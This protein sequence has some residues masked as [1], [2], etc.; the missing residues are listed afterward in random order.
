MPLTN[1]G[2][3]DSPVNL[4]YQLYGN[5]PHKVLCV[6]GLSTSHKAWIFNI[7]ELQKNSDFQICAFDN[8]GCGQSDYPSGRYTTTLM[9]QDAI[10]LLRN[11]GPEWQAAHVVGV[12]MGGMIAQ[13]MALALLDQGIKLASLTL[14]VTHAGRTVA[15]FSGTWALLQTIFKK[16]PEEKAPLVL[17]AVHSREFLES[18]H[19][20][21]KTKYDWVAEAYLERVKSDPP[22]RLSG[23]I[24]HISAVS[25]HHVSQERLHQLR[26]SGIPICIITG[27]NDSLVWHH[28]SFY[29]KDHLNPA[30]FIVW[31]GVGHGVLLERFEEFNDALVRNFRRGMSESEAKKVE[32]PTIAVDETPL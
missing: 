9:A 21:G 2:S 6:T 12:S 24:G 31:E 20:D 30:E 13:E 17:A 11:L 28:N 4:F 14:C 16:T 5:G 15:P 26:D 19:T 23:F 7:E 32:K 18:P 25:T 22:P 1:V 10:N 29:L 8:R 3:E 27:T